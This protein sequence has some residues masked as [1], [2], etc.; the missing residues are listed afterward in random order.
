M[1]IS[2]VQ[3]RTDE[4][5]MLKYVVEAPDSTIPEKL[6][7]ILDLINRNYFGTKLVWPSS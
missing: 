4:I 5:L 3:A 6:F 7:L 2:T 1:N